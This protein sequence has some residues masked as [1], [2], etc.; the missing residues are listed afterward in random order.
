MFNDLFRSKRL[1]E[2]D[3]LLFVFPPAPNLTD[4]ALTVQDMGDVISGNYLVVPPVRSC[5]GMATHCDTIDCKVYTLDQV[6]PR[7][8]VPF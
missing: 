6:C 7:N 3:P 2:A 1:E 4:L 8:L 5:L